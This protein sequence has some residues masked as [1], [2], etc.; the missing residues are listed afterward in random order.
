LLVG[1]L[2]QSLSLVAVFWAMAVLNVVN[3][4]ILLM[5]REPRP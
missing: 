5:I 2:A 4:A 1:L 3:A